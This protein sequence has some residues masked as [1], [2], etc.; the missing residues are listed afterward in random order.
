MGGGR[1]EKGNGVAIL[2]ITNTKDA[3][4]SGVVRY[5]I[6]LILLIII[7]IIIQVA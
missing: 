3:R 2:D 6:I 4:W 1:Q 7:I 5:N